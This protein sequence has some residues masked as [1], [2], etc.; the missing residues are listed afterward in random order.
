[1]LPHPRELGIIPHSRQTHRPN[2]LPCMPYFI[3][4]MQQVMAFYQAY[5]VQGYGLITS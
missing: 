5:C 3:S 4:G 1:M 2:I